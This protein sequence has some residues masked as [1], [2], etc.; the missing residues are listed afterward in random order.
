MWTKSP[1]KHPV[2]AAEAVQP[3]SAVVLR[4]FPEGELTILKM[5]GI[6]IP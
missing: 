4:T 5:S 6:I 3:S 1:K 2:K